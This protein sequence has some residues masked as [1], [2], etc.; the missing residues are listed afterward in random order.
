M[1]ALF[2]F[3]SAEEDRPRRRAESGR[4]QVHLWG[5]HGALTAALAGLGR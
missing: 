5:C 2:N 3:C 1:E 4:P